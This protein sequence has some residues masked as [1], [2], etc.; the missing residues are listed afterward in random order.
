DDPLV[1]YQIHRLAEPLAPG[2]TLV[3]HYDLGYLRDGFGNSGRDT[4]IVDNG[5]FLHS[6]RYIPSVGYSRDAELANDDDRKEQDLPERGRTAAL[7]D[8]AARASA[9]TGSDSDGI[10]FAATVCTVPDQ[11]AIAPGYL[12]REWTEETGGEQ[13]RCFDYAMDAKILNFYAFLSAR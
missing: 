7:D 9:Y 3:L 6:N 10:D 1:R 12:Q 8:A 4:A 5:S 11:I 2:A 13:R